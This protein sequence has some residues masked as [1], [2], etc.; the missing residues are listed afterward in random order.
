MVF[1]GETLE[2]L[3]GRGWTGNWVA[4]LE[5][6][7]RTKWVVVVH[8]DGRTTRRN[9]S[10]AR[11]AFLVGRICRAEAAQA[12]ELGRVTI[13]FDRYAEVSVANAW[14]GSRNPIA[15]TTLASLGLDVTRLIWLDV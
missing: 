1:T 9:G 12:P 6:I 14:T 13:Y 11:S 15:Y 5:R 3:V 8:S 2:E 7:R 10:V 4:G